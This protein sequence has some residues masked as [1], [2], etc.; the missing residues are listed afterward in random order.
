MQW[1]SAQ[2][3]SN[4]KLVASST[5]PS[6]R[7]NASTASCALKPSPLIRSIALNGGEKGPPFCTAGE[8]TL[9]V[10]YSAAVLDEPFSFPGSG[11]GANVAGDIES[12]ER[13]DGEGALLVACALRFW[14]ERRSRGKEP[15]CGPA[16]E[17]VAA[18]G[19]G[20]LEKK[21]RS[22]AGE[23]RPENAAGGCDR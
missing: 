5:L 22:A 3:A 2:L 14:E 11:C 17:A 7:R 20:K 23:E 6:Y 8:A 12:G 1:R 18:A 15:C 16:E 21:S 9:E 13:W 19:G 10:M 4:R